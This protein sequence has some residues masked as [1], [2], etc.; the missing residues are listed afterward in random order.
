MENIIMEE[1]LIEVDE[2]EIKEVLESHSE[3]IIVL[4]TK[5]NIHEEKI[6]G[7]DNKIHGIEVKNATYD[8]RFNSID[9]QFDSIKTTLVRME[10]TQLQSSNILLNALSQIAIN[11]SST[12]NEIA[13]EDNKSENEIIKGKMDNNTKVVL[14]VLGIVAI[15]ITGIF[16][17]KYGVSIPAIM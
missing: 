11:T 17:A 8:E 9:S 2:H 13:K 1:E 6:C 4:Q 3:K 14:K 10:N 15:V 5:T 16:A 12:K 7:L